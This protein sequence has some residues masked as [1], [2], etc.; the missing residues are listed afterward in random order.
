MRAI[1]I[2]IRGQYTKKSRGTVTAV[3]ENVKVPSKEEI[4]ADGEYEQL[5]NIVNS[6]GDITAKFWI[7]FSVR[8][9][10]K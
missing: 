6:D 9:D 8:P 2:G 1:P 3:V 7:N 5:C 4:G 10:V